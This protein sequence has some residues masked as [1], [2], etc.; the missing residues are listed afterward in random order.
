MTGVAGEENI[1]DVL[2]ALRRLP[3]KH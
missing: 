3:P 2:A 1:E